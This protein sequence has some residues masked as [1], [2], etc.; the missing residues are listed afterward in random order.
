MLMISLFLFKVKIEGNFDQSIHKDLVRV[1][2][3]ML[4]AIKKKFLLL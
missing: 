1:K 4:L 3:C 2:Q